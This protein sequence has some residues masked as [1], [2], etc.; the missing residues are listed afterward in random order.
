[1]AL[2]A[3]RIPGISLTQAVQM[4]D[5]REHVAK[6]FQAM[7]VA[8]MNPTAEQIAKVLE[9]VPGTADVRIGQT[10]G[11]AVL[12]LNID[13]DKASR[14]GLKG[15]MCRKPWASR[16]GARGWP[17]VPKA[18]AA[19]TTWCS[20]PMPHLATETASAERWSPPMPEAGTSTPW[21]P[22]RTRSWKRR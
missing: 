22:K 14:L 10:T 5:E 9:S 4:Q 11:L 13:R 20:R 7:Q 19:S 16:R 8:V 3:L 12:T 18:T 15:A 6:T 2:H 17:G 21:S 1:M